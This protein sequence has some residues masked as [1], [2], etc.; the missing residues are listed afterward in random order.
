MI[1]VACD[2][3]A[4]PQTPALLLKSTSANLGNGSQKWKFT[5]DG[6]RCG[7][8]TLKLLYITEAGAD[9]RTQY[10]YE[11]LGSSTEGT[12]TLLEKHGDP[13]DRPGQINID[14][15]QAIPAGR[16]S[17][18]DQS[19]PILHGPFSSTSQ[20]VLPDGPLNLGVETVVFARRM[21]NT[22]NDE[23]NTGGVES[24]RKSLA[25]PKD[26]IIA[27]TLRWYR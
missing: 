21:A 26:V 13:S 2:K 24:L 18:Q 17:A 4:P 9:V 16:Q 6:H 20:Y 11:N 7:S 25:G 12:I 27:I 5:L 15:D 3:P 10:D 1:L 23:F 19:F 14:L 8:I 22:S